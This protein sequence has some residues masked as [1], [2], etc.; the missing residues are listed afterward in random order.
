MG[1]VTIRA[2]E[3]VP[4]G[5][6][7]AH[8][9]NYNH[10]D[11]G[12]ISVSLDHLG[13]YRAIVVSEASGNILAGNHTW[14]AAQMNGATE[15][16]AH[17][18]PNLS[19]EDEL[20][21]LVGDN[22]YARLATVDPY[23]LSEMLTE[24]AHSADGLVATGY[25]G[26][27]L[28]DLLNDL[29][30][31]DTGREGSIIEPPDNPTTKLGDRWRL[32]D[33]LL[34]CGDAFDLTLEGDTVITDPPYGMHLDTDF[35]SY[36][37]RGGT[38]APVIGDDTPFDPTSLLARYSAISEQVWFGADYYRQHL[39]EGGSWYAWD[40]RTDETYAGY[41]EPAFDAAHGSQ[42][43]LAWSRTPHRR[44]LLRFVWAGHHG[45]QREDTTNRVHPTQ[46]PVPLIERLLTITKA[47][48]VID[49]F[50]GSGSTLIAADNL[51]I[52]S[53][54][55]ELDPGYCDVIIT[56]WESLHPNNHAVLMDTDDLKDTQ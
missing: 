12:A 27:M 13:Q 39:P 2:T 22:Q 43:E 28:D 15:I 44:E 9:E 51:G 37:D 14:M 26:D 34:I 33:H 20:R 45:L 19:P 30:E 23:Q 35:S 50:A 40:K 31:D 10:G 47:T 21:I 16:L 41:Q 46:K 42:F 17:L 6:I 53:Q 4:I 56:R 1:K 48:Q 32:G 7:Q 29:L 8:P 49:P 18:I 54:V 3:P 5:S 24:L 25:D 52:P 55:S 11:A 38:Y 36:H